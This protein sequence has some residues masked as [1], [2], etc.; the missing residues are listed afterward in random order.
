MGPVRYGRLSNCDGPGE[1]PLLDVLAFAGQ[2]LRCIQMASSFDVQLDDR[3]LVQIRCNVVRRY[4]D[5]LHAARVSLMV[6]FRALDTIRR[7]FRVIA[8]RA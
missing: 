3:A 8:G 6:G 5:Q 1:H 7:E 4:A 2:G